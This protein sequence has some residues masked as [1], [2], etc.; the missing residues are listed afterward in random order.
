MAFQGYQSDP[1]A[2]PL[3]PGLQFDSNH[4]PLVLTPSDE[5]AEKMKPPA[6]PTEKK[7]ITRNRASYSCLMCRKRKIRCDKVNEGAPS[8]CARFSYSLVQV[9]PIC[10]NCSKTNEQCV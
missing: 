10:E 3:R 8:S 6:P 2:R 1:S 4:P 9:H 7:P 5:S